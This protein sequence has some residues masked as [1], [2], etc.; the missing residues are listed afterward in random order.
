MFNFD[1]SWG[2]DSH[3]PVRHSFTIRFPSVG[4]GNPSS[5]AATA[6]RL[7]IPKNASF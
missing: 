5:L 3:R 6:H 2:V 7:A 1:T 4:F